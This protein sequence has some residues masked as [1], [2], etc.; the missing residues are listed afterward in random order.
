MRIAGYKVCLTRLPVHIELFLMLL[1]AVKADS[2]L[3]MFATNSA[4]TSVACNWTE[5]WEPTA[6]AAAIKLLEELG[7]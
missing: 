2:P 6:A 3:V 5:V 7:S 1:C 4:S